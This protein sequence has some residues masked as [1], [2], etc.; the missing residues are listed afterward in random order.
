M[1]DAAG[2][3]NQ[4]KHTVYLDHTATTPLDP[5]VRAAME[6][7]FAGTFGNP[8]SVHAFGR[9]AKQ[10]LERA[11]TTIARL[12]GAEPGEIFFTG[13]GTEAD[14]LA[15]LGVAVGAGQRAEIVTGAAEHHA[16]LD[17]CEHIAL[18]G[19]RT[20]VLPV[21]PSGVV[22][23]DAVRESLSPATLLVSVMQANN[24]VG[25]IAPIKA[26]GEIVHAQ[27]AFL[28]TDAVQSAGRIPVSVD[29]LGVDLLSISA[30]KM[31]G[32]KGVG[33]LY[34]RRTCPVDP[35]VFGGGQE[36]GKRPGT[37][38]V[39]GAVGFA[40]AFRLSVE[41]MEEESARL[42]GMRNELENRL[43]S[44]FPALL[45]NGEGALRLPHILSVSFDGALL[46]LEG[47]MLVVNMDLE[48][49]AV[50][51]GSACTSGSVQA[52]H[53]L[54]AMGR[55][56]KTARATIR[57]SFGRANSAADIDATCEALRRTIAR[58][59]P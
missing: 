1:A 32:P 51:S 22:T 48:G 31:Y 37:E 20:R 46:P 54:L 6:P 44:L 9:E 42:A 3:M 47:E 59:S 56:E 5:H 13:G 14:N 28:H 50:S 29:D 45:V 15:L 43:R 34:V 36:R 40:E 38:N 18:T 17:A 12:I 21:D 23:L 49:I 30:H 39:A 2:T 41:R 26:I 58:M 52:S 7:F 24:E 19:R 53:V 55:D 35:I 27:G 57:F 11:R 16:V 4:R 25:T 10:G 8:S 33:A